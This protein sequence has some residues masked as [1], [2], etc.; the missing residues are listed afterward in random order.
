MFYSTEFQH[1]KYVIVNK[2]KKKVCY[3]RI[4][5]YMYQYVIYVYGPVKRLSI[6]SLINTRWEASY[7]VYEYFLGTPDTHQL[8]VETSSL[9]S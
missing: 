5:L 7:T 9:Y 6:K 3:N 4:D 8:P 2:F 1:N